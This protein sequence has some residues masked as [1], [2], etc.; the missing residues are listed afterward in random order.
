MQGLKFDSKWKVPI[1][2]FGPLHLM[3]GN[4]SSLT[5]FFFFFQVMEKAAS[6]FNP[7]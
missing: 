2:G 4:Y 7:C 6:D 5:F 3:M 1:F